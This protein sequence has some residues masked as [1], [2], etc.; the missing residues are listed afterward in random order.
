VR[1]STGSFRAL[2][3]LLRT[4]KTHFTSFAFFSHKLLRWILPLLMIV[5]F[6]SNLF[7]LDRAFYRFTLAAQLLILLWAA[8]GYLFREQL[9][10]VRFSLVG[11]FLV[12]MNL[13]FLVGLVRCLSGGKEVAWQRTS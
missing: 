8:L 10:H 4:P 3:A 2:P 12:A 6:A 1:I 7:V 11:Y 9:S 13:A 5:I